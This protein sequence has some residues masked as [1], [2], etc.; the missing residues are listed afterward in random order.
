MNKLKIGLG[1]SG[2]VDSAVSLLLL[3]KEFEEIDSFYLNCFQNDFCSNN[4]D[5]NDA[6]LVAKNLKSTFQ[7]IDLIKDYKEKV[8]EYFFSELKKGATPNPD[9]IC[10]QEIKFGLFYKYL[11]KQ[12]FDFIATGHYA[13]ILK[14]ENDYYL[15]S[16]KDLTKDQSY[17][18]CKLKEAQLQKIKFPL[19]H[20]EK[21]EVRKIA[22]KNKLLVAQKKD[23][24]GICFLGNLNFSYLL[25]NNLGEKKGEIVDQ[26][27]NFLGNH[28]GH[29]F[30]TIGQKVPN[31]DFK[32]IKKSSLFTKINQKNIPKFY[33]IA[34]NKIANQ[35]IV[36]LKK[37][38]LKS[39]VYL[40][41]FHLIY[42]KF[43]ITNLLNQNKINLF[44]KYRNTSKFVTCQ[45]KQIN[46]KIKLIL[47]G[48]ESSLAAGQFAVLYFNTLEF[49]NTYYPKLKINKKQKE[50][51][52]NNFICLGC[53][54]IC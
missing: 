40:K 15:S 26:K 38:S 31:L 37:D 52:Q 48:E 1:L 9:I 41:K 34:K 22:Q 28:N 53:A 54:T 24:M 33:V 36:G 44:V 11:E 35:I 3:Q 16:G 17:F 18:L 46:D 14:F 5:R 7:A 45:L 12:N 13:Q 19:G 30:Y 51:Y 6:F 42:S 32:L 39:E 47:K 27:N 43:Q 10:N 23:S 21:K 2:G 50:N 4:Q 8:L 29:W 49:I 25:K 20:L